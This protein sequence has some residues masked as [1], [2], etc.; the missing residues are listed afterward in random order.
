[1]MPHTACRMACFTPCLPHHTLRLPCRNPRR[2]TSHANPRG[3]PS[4]APAR[5]VPIRAT[6][7]CSTASICG[8]HARCLHCYDPHGTTSAVSVGPLCCTDQ[9]GGGRR[10]PE[11][12]GG[13]RRVDKGRD[14]E[15]WGW[16][17]GEKGGWLE[18]S[19]CVLQG[20]WNMG[21]PVRMMYLFFATLYYRYIGA[22]THIIL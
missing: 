1:M 17:A 5:P 9:A 3:Q 7:C 19:P 15:N 11:R 21:N 2:T 16:R 22:S 6:C 12:G 4:S 13:G 8:Q 14:L 10:G 18:A 20:T